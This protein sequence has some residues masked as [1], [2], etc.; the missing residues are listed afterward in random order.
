[1]DDKGG[2]ISVYTFPDK[3]EIRV[4]GIL[5]QDKTGRGLEHNTITKPTSTRTEH[6]NK[7]GQGVPIV[8]DKKEI[9]VQDKVED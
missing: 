5:L 8:Q 2:Y 3:A 9:S 6:D 7:H 4:Q 1:M